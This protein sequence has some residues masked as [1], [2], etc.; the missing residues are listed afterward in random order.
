MCSSESAPPTTRI[1]WSLSASLAT[2]LYVGTGNSFS[3]ASG[4][5]SYVLGLQGPCMSVD[6]A[7]SSS[8]LAVH[9]AAESL[10]RK[11]CHTALVAGVN[12]MLVPGATAVLC[13]GRML[14]FS[15]L[16]KT[17]DAEADGY[18]RGEG[19]G[20]V[21]L[22]RLSDAL[23]A[24]Q[25][26]LAVVRGSAVNQDGRSSGLTAPNG[27]AQEALLRAALKSAGI[28]AAQVGY[29]EA[30][31]TGTPLGDPIEMRAI[32][33]VLGE[34][35][36]AD[37]P[38]LVGSAKTNIGHLEAAAGIA[39]FIKAVL[40]LHHGQIPPHLHLQKPNPH[41]AW[42]EIPIRVPTEL[43]AWPDVDGPR[44]AGVSSFGFSGTNT[45]V[46]LEAAPPSHFARS[47]PDRPLHVVP[48]SARS[49]AALDA[50]VRLFA[51]TAGGGQE[52]PDI[53][54]TAATGRA[55]FR[56]RAAAI[57]Q[58]SAD[59]ERQLRA[60]DGGLVRGVAEPGATKI[61]FLFTG[62]GSQQIDMGRQL[63][64]T[65]PQFK[66]ALEQCDRLFQ[67]H[68]GESIIALLYGGETD[69]A[70]RGARLATTKYTQP[71]LFSVEYTLAELWL[72]WGVKPLAV[73]GH[74]LGEYRSGLCGGRVQSRGRYVARRR[75]R[76]AHERSADRRQHGGRFCAGHRGGEGDRA[77]REHRVDCR[78]ERPRQRGDFRGAR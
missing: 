10:R 38:L 4:R 53:A 40:A 34:G 54:F 75:A 73:M 76:E 59:I 48:I 37:R 6:T 13:R 15:G 64:E 62:Q 51:E 18:V 27:I 31:G 2:D 20:V 17:F 71:A 22:R 42:S 39:G 5:L 1:Y 3:I 68:L 36:P 67:P 63:Y 24:G 55:H 47:T 19:C 25:R 29:V 14:S 41:I 11:E 78:G 46:I 70:T 74:S 7:C 49:E 77:I 30:H 23:S 45:H 50:A 66:R 56:H 58:D 9:L 8:L 44:V 32:A 26:I 65:A 69:A 28:A 60:A 57:G 72:S 12:L 61:A 35:R 21:V 52:L 43:Q 16:C 33:S